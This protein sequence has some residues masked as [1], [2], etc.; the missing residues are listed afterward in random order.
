VEREGRCEPANA[1]AGDDH[2]II[3][4]IPSRS[5]IS[6]FIIFSMA[7]GANRRRASR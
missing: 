7:A 4:H 1:A 2:Q 3:R 5:E 6:F